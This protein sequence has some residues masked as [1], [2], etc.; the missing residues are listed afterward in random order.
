MFLATS[1]Q[2]WL[3]HQ[4]SNSSDDLLALLQSHPCADAIAFLRQLPVDTERASQEISSAIRTHQPRTVLCC[5]MAEKRKYLSLERYAR[6]G[7]ATLATTL[8]LDDLIA[9]LSHT[10]ISHDAGTFV[11]NNTYYQLLHTIH[12]EKTSFHALF[13]HVPILTPSNQ[14]HLLRDLCT[15][16]E[17][18]RRYW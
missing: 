6:N 9:S 15:L 2:T 8:P 10:R 3:P 5:G 7:S 17:S 16:V 14:A 4:S 13:I 12:Q 18:L 11:C 1:F